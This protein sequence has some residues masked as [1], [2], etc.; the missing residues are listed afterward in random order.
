MNIEV[1]NDLYSRAKNLGY[2]KSRESFRVLIS[3]NANVFNDNYEYIKSQGYTKGQDS[4]RELLGI[5]V[6]KKDISKPGILLQS[7]FRHRIFYRHYS[8]ESLKTPLYH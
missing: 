7:K 4:F 6:K 8:P 1:L 5:D 3:E 2:S